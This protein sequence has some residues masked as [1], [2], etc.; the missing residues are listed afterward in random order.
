MRH[1]VVAHAHAA[2]LDADEVAGEGQV[3]GD[4]VEQSA[5][6]ALRV[7]RFLRAELDL[8]APLV[9]VLDQGF[10]QRVL[11]GAHAGVALALQE[12]AGAGV[13]RRHEAVAPGRAEQR[14]CGGRRRLDVP[15]GLRLRLLGVALAQAA[16]H[17]DE[18]QPARDAGLPCQRCL[19]RGRRADGDQRHRLGRRHHGVDE[20]LDAVV[21]HAAGIARQHVAVVGL[22]AVLLPLAHADA[23]RHVGAAGQ[24]E[25]AGDDP[26]AVDGV[27]VVGH[28]EPD[29]ELGRAQCKRQRPHVV[30]VVP[31]VGGEDDR[32]AGRRAGRR[33]RRPAR[34]LPAAARRG[35]RSWRRDEARR[36]TCYPPA[37]H[38]GIPPWRAPRSGRSR[39][40][41][42]AAECKR[43]LAASRGFPGARPS[44]ARR[45]SA[46][47]RAGR[48]HAAHDARPSAAL[49]PSSPCSRTSALLPRSP[50]R[51][52]DPGERPAHRDDR[53]ARGR[54]G[55]SPR[56]QG[57]RAR[58]RAARLPAGRPVG[59]GAAGALRAAGRADPARPGRAGAP[60]QGRPARRPL[61]G[62]R[63]ALPPLRPEPDRAFPVPAP[64]HEAARLLALRCAGRAR[65]SRNRLG[66]AAASDGG[67]PLGVR[68]AL[69][70]L[71]ARASGRWTSGS[72]MPGSASWARS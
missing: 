41:R 30:D 1:P 27:A 35:R 2:A 47:S 12:H 21:D 9:V 20:R 42:G 3:D 40:G 25:V 13:E 55:P 54:C 56:L 38:R 51:A 28:H 43:L 11:R 65:L 17:A 39:R 10:R 44:A 64:G 7:L 22:R 72:S 53:Q 36:I 16:V 31:D 37:S 19:Q 70:Q 45:P 14:A 57:T 5:A 15:L 71:H 68:R 58:V 29:V 6:P 33:L 63:G 23:D 62:A 32:D 60:L 24:L 26:R 18:A 49:W 61:A 8:R 66:R 46:G 34:A 48:Y 52:G 59:D 4:G 67:A 50:S 69:P